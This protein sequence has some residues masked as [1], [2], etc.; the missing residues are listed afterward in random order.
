MTE[1]PKRTRNLEELIHDQVHDKI[2]AG[3]AES[4]DVL[5][6][7]ILTRMLPVMENIAKR[8]EWICTAIAPDELGVSVADRIREVT[9]VLEY[10]ANQAKREKK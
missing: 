2:V 4:G 9:R 10:S 3:N 8:L 5:N 7:I 1:E 6:A